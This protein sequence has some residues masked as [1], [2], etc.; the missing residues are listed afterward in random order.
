MPVLQIDNP[1]V[2]TYLAQFD[3]LNPEEQRFVF[4]Q[5]ERKQIIVEE[6]LRPDDDWQPDPARILPN[7]K[8]AVGDFLDYCKELNLL[9][10]TDKEVEQIRYDALMEKYG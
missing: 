8:T 2:E 3:R 9:P 10:L 4:S 5:L 6:K 1:L 7:G